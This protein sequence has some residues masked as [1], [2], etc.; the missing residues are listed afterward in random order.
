MASDLK[1]PEATPR[2]GTSQAGRVLVALDPGYVS[3]DERRVED[4]L[5]FAHA[6]GKGLIYYD[7]NDEP[8]GDFGAFVAGSIPPEEVPAFF[9]EVAAFLKD[10]AGFDPSTKPALFRP[11]F[12]LFLVFLT[13]FET[14]KGELNGLTRRHLDF[15]YRQILRMVKKGPVADR[16]N[17][18]FE[19]SPGKSEA[20][21]RRGSLLSAG[22]DK[23][24]R[25]R[26]YA[27]DRDLVVNRAEIAQLRSVFVERRRTGIA[28]AREL[29][30]GEPYLGEP[31]FKQDRILGAVL[32]MFRIALGEPR[33]GD[34]LPMYNGHDINR[35][36]LIELDNLTQNARED[37]GLYL[38]LSEVRDIVRLHEY[39]PD[40]D[41]QKEI[42]RL[43]KL[44]T[45]RKQKDPAHSTPVIQV[46]LD[47]ILN[48]YFP[49][50]KQL[51]DYFSMSA[52]SFH[53]ILRKLDGAD[54]PTW[55][56]V[57][58][59]L[60]EAYRQKLR[61]RRKE[62]IYAVTAEPRLTAMIRHVLGEK[63][64]ADE[65]SGALS[66]LEPFLS[67]KDFSK[68]E[69]LAKAQEKDWEQISV[70]LEI[71]ERNRL[72]E[73]PPGTEGWLNISPADDAVAAGAR[74]LQGTTKGPVQWATFGK[75]C[76]ATKSTPPAVLGFAV[77][78][79]LL[80]LREGDR[81]ITLSLG[82]QNEGIE[83]EKLKA[84]VA[85]AAEAAAA[86]AHPLLFQISTGEDWVKLDPPK[87]EVNVRDGLLFV[88]FTFT[89]EAK[90][91]AIAAPPAK[92]AGIGGSAPV[93]KLLLQPIWDEAKQSY[94]IVYEEL[95]GLSLSA[96]QIAVTAAGLRALK[97]QND[98][99]TLDPKKP[100]YPFGTAPTVGSRFM[101]GHPEIVTKKLDRLTFQFH[102]MG[103]P[104]DFGEHYKHYGIG[105]SPSFTVDI[106]VVDRDKKVA[107]LK[108]A[109]PLFT[110]QQEKSSTPRAAQA[111]VIY[112]PIDITTINPEAN[113]GDFESISPSSFGSEVT[114][115]RR[116][117]QWELNDPDFQ[118]DAY[119]TVAATKAVELAADIA[120]AA[121]DP[122]ADP[123]DPLKYK[124]NP[125]YTPKL[126]YLTID[127]ES[128]VKVRFDQENGAE[129]PVR[130]FH[131]HPFGEN[132]IEVERTG[133]GLPFLPRYEND[134]ELY[135]GLR[136]VIPPQN[137][138]ILFQLAEGSADPDLEPQPVTWSYLDGDR[139]VPL[140][141]R[142]SRDTT[143][144]FINAGILE[145]ALDPAAPSTR[146]GGGFYWLRA[147]VARDT[148]SLCDTIARPLTQAMSAVL[149]S[150]DN[151]P[152]HFRD[153]LP[154]E[155][156]KKIITDTPGI[157]AVRQP[158]P[159]FGGRMA[160]D[161]TLS[162]TRMSERLRHKQRALSVW[163]YERLV[164]E[165]FPEI[166]KA[167]CLPARPDKPGAVE[168]IVIPD[169]RK[170]L[171]SDPFQP[172]APS[173]LLADVESYL[174]K[175]APVFASVTARNAR[176]VA[177]RVSLRVRFS[178]GCDEGYSTRTLNDEL[179]RFLSP[180]AYEEGA[181]VAIG[182]KIYANSIVDFVDRREYVDYVA[183]V[184]FLKSKDGKAFEPVLPELSATSDAEGYF[185]EASE[186]DEVLV[187]DRT[188]E[189]YV[190]HE[191]LDEETRFMGIDFMHVEFDFVVA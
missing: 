185:V 134:G 83:Q 163:D 96:V 136:N 162:A 118:H 180:W 123:I 81:K 169:T 54:E 37:R 126:K 27:T 33:P 1:E 165:N 9:N 51:E 151:A 156:I 133:S 139:W 149:V 108:A 120:A 72:G 179:N 173:K 56:R 92:F 124:V 176:Y 34:P 49:K 69:D 110:K 141:H 77:S 52:E 181:D 8:A 30:L 7:L 78:S 157:A 122:N 91:P 82:F 2:D 76:A 106:S 19:L 22:A 158:Y 168:V 59:I 47:E 62:A 35:D 16:V 25:D 101:I 44:S 154:A 184:K 80:A 45:E 114:S 132:D 111:P 191:D 172:K 13:L 41:P 85:P 161:E 146:V 98:D 113:K 79:P 107:T 66:R 74:S 178:A 14:L 152:D 73:P 90:F 3:V 40:V 50:I 67:E 38:S 31:E 171:L 43:L 87:G 144:G 24:G 6:Y 155:T 188:H 187:A 145:I 186:P 61:R 170:L 138:S 93:L 153:P 57:D 127:Y 135:I 177:V 75:P 102:W 143:R 89:I 15:Y 97:L 64:S 58:A 104:G 32:A 55:E 116:Y 36:L 148:S 189:I 4:L 119:A 131:I 164:L 182:G 183:A 39:P 21:V 42:N 28:E 190:L 99:T 115:F 129:R 11:H 142:L 100:F 105:E 70:L 46:T 53:D 63:P 20:L 125:P 71:A 103:A 175:K 159:S 26:V 130:A 29:Y 137:V 167:K 112:E 109:A 86:T 166:Y 10:P 48:S 12:V 23:L 128:S 18:I 5:A 117:L 17:V 160:E 88:D 147:A 121:K 174:R 150:R 140:D 65:D 95:S 84:I 60:T 68:L 94:R